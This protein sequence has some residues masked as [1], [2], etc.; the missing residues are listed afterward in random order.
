NRK[1]LLEWL[2]YKA[3]HSKTVTTFI[4]S[5][6]SINATQEIKEDNDPVYYFI[7][8]YFA[9]LESTRIPSTFLFN[10]FMACMDA[11]N[12][13]S[14]IKQR[15][16]TLRVQ[17]ILKAKGWEYTPTPKLK[18]LNIGTVKISKNLMS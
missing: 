9:D 10:Y 1:E 13:H 12:N 4:Q 2:L 6:E 17:K 11:E 16:F 7:N 3:L 18:P 14:R 5:N 15:T 8:K